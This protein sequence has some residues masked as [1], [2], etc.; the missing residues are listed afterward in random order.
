M[1]L[2]VV[3]VFE[4]LM[5][6]VTLGMFWSEFSYEYKW[7]PDE[8]NMLYTLQEE[9]YGQ[10]VKDYYLNEF[11]NQRV[12]AGLRECYG[13]ARYFEAALWY[14]AYDIVGDTQRS[15]VYAEKMEE[16]YDEMGDYQFL[17]AEI[18]KK[19]DME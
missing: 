6:I 9:Q 5:I 2:T 18:R 14:N 12:T 7:Y 13:V 1:I 17:D 19:L 15:A 4:I 3:M 16:A 10:L 8:D 11:S